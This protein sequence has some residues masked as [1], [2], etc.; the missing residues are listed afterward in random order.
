MPK[1]GLVMRRELPSEEYPEAS[2]VPR[3]DGSLRMFISEVA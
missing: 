1:D 3:A 2:Y